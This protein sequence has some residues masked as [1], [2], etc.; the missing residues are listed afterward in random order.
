MCSPV[1]H[2]LAAFTVSWRPSRALRFNAAV[3]LPALCILSV[4]PDIDFYPGLLIGHPNLYHHGWTHSLFFCG[5]VAGLIAAF[6]ALARKPGALKAGGLCL[7]VLISHLVLDCLSKDRTPPYG[8]QVFWP[9]S[10]R[11]VSSPVTLFP[12]V[13]KGPDNGT[14]LLRLF[15][16]HNARTLL[17]ETC[18]LGP[19]AAWTWFRS[20]KTAGKGAP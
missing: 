19:F 6:L 12:D 11:F 7:L 15:T 17:V 14:F 13:D 20:R 1:G 10:E 3:W 18:I 4:L 5:G 9:F 16:L 8:L 2:G